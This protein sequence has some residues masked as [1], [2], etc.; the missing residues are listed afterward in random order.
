M[1]CLTYKGCFLNCCCMSYRDCSSTTCRLTYKRCYCTCYRDYRGKTTMDV[2]LCNK[3]QVDDLK[4]KLAEQEIELAEKNEDANKLIAI[5][6]AETEKVAQE[7]AI[8]DEE[9]IKVQIINEEVSQKAK[10][11]S[12]DLAKAEPALQAAMEA[13][14]TLNKKNLTEMKSF[15]SPPA[16]VIN[17]ASA[18]MVLLAPDGRIPADRSWKAAKATVMSKVDAFLT[19]LKEYNK[20]NIHENCRKAIQPYLNDKDFNPEFI[21]AKS[22]AAAGLC[23]WVINIM[24]FYEVFCD[25]EPKRI[26]LNVANAELA[27]AQEKLAFL[28]AKLVQLELSLASLT[29]KFQK[30]TDAKLKCQAEADATN[31]TIVLANR[32]VGGLASENVRW[33][34]SINILK[35]QE[36]TLPG[37]ILLV[38]S[39]VSY[40]GCF[41]KPYRL[42]LLEK[43][44]I[45]TLENIKDIIPIS[46]EFEPLSLLIDDTIIAKWNNDWL[47]SDKMSIE[48]ATILTT[49]E[50]WPLVIDPQLQ[51]IKWIKQNFAANLKTV[52]IGQKGYMDV[53]EAA[54]SSGDTVLIEN[55]GE[56]IDPILNPL[57]G[58]NTIKKQLEDFLLARLSAAEGNFLGD[59][60]L[61]ENLETTK[62]TAAEIETKVAEAKTT[63]REIND[64]RENYRPAACRASLIY[65]LLGDLNKIHPMYQFSLKAFST[66]FEKAIEQAELAEDVSERVVN[67]IDKITYSVYQYTTRGLFERDKLIFTSQLTFQILL[68]KN[69]LNAKEL[70]F[71]LR[72]PFIPNLI[73]PVNF[74]SHT[75]WGGIKNVHLVAKWLSQLEKKLEQYS[76]VSHDNYRVFISAEPAASAESH[77]IPHGIL[78]SA[79]KIINEPPSGMQA[80]LHK[81]LN[82]F[83]QETL[84]MCAR[85]TEFKSILFVLCY[86][87]AV[88]QER[89]KFGPQGWN[90]SYPFNVGDLTI[91]VNVL[92]NYLE[93]NNKVPWEDLRYLFGEIMYGGHITDDWDRRLCR[94]YLE[95]YMHPDMVKTILDEMTEKLP[96]EFIMAELMGKVP[97]EERTPYVVVAFQECER[98]NLLISEIKRTLKELDLGLKGELTITSDMEDLSNALYMDQ[99]PN[100]WA[101]RA[102]PSLYTLTAWYADLIQRVKE[103]E[104]WVS[105][106]QLPAAVWLAGFFN[107]QSFLTAIMQQM[108]RKNEWPL[109]KMCIQCDVTKKCRDDMAGPPRE[110]AFIHGLFMEGARWDTQT[111]MIGES[112]LKELTPMLPI[113][114]LKAIPVDRQETKN[115]Y[116][117]PVYKTKQR[118]PTFVWTFNL[119]TKEKSS[120]WI[121]GGVCLLLQV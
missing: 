48:N 56:S 69:D 110:G 117:C 8:A 21:Y 16:A 120:K 46:S 82:N 42:E 45:T 14:D 38:S 108:A 13:L 94:T 109:D 18:V 83:T 118:G 55:I 113:V 75:G 51:G 98:M 6:G 95:V 91:S 76:L 71:L 92:Y 105:D 97:A 99:V 49:C 73:S 77:I 57:L 64:A 68:L 7:K 25:V 37:D 78:E 2:A 103:L 44:W 74:I 12:E 24:K 107:P 65:F 89:R 111:G 62:S 87:H 114:F 90:R 53:I 106:F 33:A 58:R 101:N 52:R 19:N 40:L 20:E 26:A 28:Q 3:H 70:D 32:L 61:V 47:P 93:A 86:F 36:K 67:L 17:V 119:K 11:C 80:N 22:S 85:E 79:I 23:A 30:A 5:V 1:H 4:A 84:E 96:D 121:L 100:G 27:A 31:N 60:A 81:A 88:V 102:Y 112:L 66:V 104:G 63:E 115:I 9:A 15:G 41:T 35:E 39:F 59:Y 29:A 116:Q 43:I 54:V 10:D 34:E 72:F 50:R